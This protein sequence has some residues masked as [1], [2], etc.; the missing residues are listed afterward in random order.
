VL[1]LEDR[2]LPDRGS[3]VDGADPSVTVRGID[4]LDENPRL[5]G[6]LTT[7]HSSVMY[8]IPMEIHTPLAKNTWLRPC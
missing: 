5:L 6:V 4:E 2:A 7:A 1:I 8:S 3:T